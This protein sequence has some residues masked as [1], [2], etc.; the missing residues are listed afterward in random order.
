[1]LSVAFMGEFFILQKPP[2]IDLD[3]KS[4]EHYSMCQFPSIREVI[5]GKY[6][7]AAVLFVLENGAVFT[8]ITSTLGYIGW[9][10]P[11]FPLYRLRILLL[12]SLDPPFCRFLL[13]VY[14]L[15]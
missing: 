12:A 5:F 13:Y 1:M 9:I 10:K 14:P 2:P 6:C 7:I 8:V 4:V 11:L 3:F 15:K